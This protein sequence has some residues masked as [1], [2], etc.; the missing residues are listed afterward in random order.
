MTRASR[1]GCVVVSL[2]AILAGPT[3]G[4]GAG[5]DGYVG[6]E[7]C[8]AC[9]A[10]VFEAMQ[11]GAHAIAP[12]WDAETACES[13]HGPGEAHVESGGEASTIVNLGEL[14]PLEA[15]A[16]C[17]TCH[18]RQESHFKVGQS[19]HRLGDVGCN[20][21][22][23]PHSSAE[24][25]LETPASE[26][27]ASCHQAIALQFELPRSH[28]LDDQGDGCV[29]CHNPHGTRS[30]RT[31]TPLFDQTCSD[32]HVEKAG[33]FIYAHDTSIVDGC[34]GCHEVHGSPNRHLLKHEPQVNLCYQCHS[35]SVTP[36]W[37][38]APRFLNEKCT[39]CHTAIHG[40]NT[41]PYF[42]EE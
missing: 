2:A 36:V 15:S 14:P 29:S 22:H 23:S 32:C 27:C 17:V 35:A 3:L 18:K 25:M 16:A 1:V 28:P 7:T 37:H 26:L 6:S 4:S 24:G 41:N 19:I 21:C 40:S 33:P 13:C 42:L 5:G 39:A 11:G 10:D 12:G 8:S 38:S 31:S 34:S 9:H 20:D 30:L